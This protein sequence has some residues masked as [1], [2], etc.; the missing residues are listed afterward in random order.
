M[1]L[2]LEAAPKAQVVHGRTACLVSLDDLADRA[3]RVLA[4]GEVLDLRG[5]RVRYVDTPHVPHAWES[6]LAAL[7]PNRLAVMHGSA[8]PAIVPPS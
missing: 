1:N 8:M 7:K 5:R 6:G 2:W 3:P 4:N